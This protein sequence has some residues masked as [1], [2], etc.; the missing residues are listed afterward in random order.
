MPVIFQYKNEKYLPMD[1][2]SLVSGG[3]WV[4]SGAGVLI[5][6]GMPL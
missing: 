6:R 2:Q 4:I 1:L 3:F 5:K